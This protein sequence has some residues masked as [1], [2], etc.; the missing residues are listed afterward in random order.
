MWSGRGLSPL[1]VGEGKLSLSFSLP[2]TT[3][4]Y[5]WEK[6]GRNNLRQSPQC[7]AALELT[8]FNSLHEFT[9]YEH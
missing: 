3:L 6:T 4:D 1:P 7:Q 5:R 2:P 8:V 9:S